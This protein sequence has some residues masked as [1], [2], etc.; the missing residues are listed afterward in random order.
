MEL[1]VLLEEISFQAACGPNLEY[2]PE[3]MALEQAAQG[4]PEQQF[5]DMIVPAVEPDWDDVRARAEALFSRTKDLRVAILLV[6]ALLRKTDFLGLHAGLL[7]LVQLLD[8]YWE[9]IYPCLEADEGNDPTMRLNVLGALIDADG[10]LRDMHSMHL[11]PPGVHGRI[12]VRDV[13]IANGKLP[14][15]PQGALNSGQVEGI[16]KAAATDHAE[17]IHAARESLQAAHELQ[18]LLNNKLGIKQT[19]NLQPLTDILTVVVETCHNAL[20]DGGSNLIKTGP[21]D[22][23]NAVIPLPAAHGE[24]RSREDCIRLLDRLCEFM[25]RTEP[26]NPAPLLIRRAQGLI[27][28]NFIEI[29]EDLAPDS[30]GAIK[31][32]AGLGRHE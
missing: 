16:L 13:L 2:D 7:L 20:D 27:S 8:R 1:A 28:K 30:L 3:F 26:S 5:G 18:T 29:I 21:G 17:S 23:K 4:K 12:I 32:I 31:G 6:R 24:I 25:E 10:F 19:L 11:V 22:A 9:S 14:A 15:G